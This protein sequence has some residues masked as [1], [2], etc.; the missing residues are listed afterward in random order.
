MIKNI[1]KRIIAHSGY[2]IARIQSEQEQM[3]FHRDFMKDKRDLLGKKKLCILDAGAYIGEMALGYRQSFP[4][5]RIIALEP[6]PETF[7]VLKKKTQNQNIECY[8]LALAEETG[9]AQLQLFKHAPANSMLLP[10]SNRETVWGEGVLDANGILP[11]QAVSLIDAF[12]DFGIQHLDLLKLDVQG[13]EYKI[14]N[15]AKTLLQKGAVDYVYLELILLPT[16]EQQEPFSHYLNLMEETGFELHNMYNLSSIHG[17]L[18]Q[19]D[20]LFKRKK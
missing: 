6:F 1:L 19:V 8:P 7:E 13:M 11:I 9:T 15:G 18:R 10:H 12:R 14:L 3:F 4:E 16:Y 5:A 2:S 20:A 17:Q